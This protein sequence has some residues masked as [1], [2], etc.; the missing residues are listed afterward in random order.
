MSIRMVAVELYRVMKQTEELEKKLQ[1]LK[2]G[3]PERE[4][5][6]RKLREAEAEKIRLQKMLEGAKE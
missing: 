4:E 5:I 6:E 1:D 3:S 2:P